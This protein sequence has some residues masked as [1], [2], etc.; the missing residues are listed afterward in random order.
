MQSHAILYAPLPV[1]YKNS[2]GAT[3]ME[4]RQVRYF[5]A[6]AEH[7]SY[8]KA[9]EELHI[10]VSPLSRQVRQL[11]DEFGVR[12]FAR[13]RRRVELTNAGRLFLEEARALVQ[14]TADVSDR[15]R[16]VKKGESGAVRV[17]VGL[18][19]GD[20]V[21]SVAAEHAKVHPDVDIQCQGIFSTLQ[22]EA[23]RENKIDVGFLRPPVD[24]GL[25]SELLYEERLVALVG[26]TNPLSKRKTIRAKDLADEILFLPDRSVG[27]GLREKI[28]QLFAKA[29]V[30]PR[31]SS[32]EA[33]PLGGSEVHKV[34]LAAN[35]G[36]FIVADELGTR[37]EN[38]N[39]AAAIPLDDPDAHIGLYMAWRK[40]EASS[41]ILAVLDTARRVLGSPAPSVAGRPAMRVP[42]LA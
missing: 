13:D 22:N 39:V 4:L 25:R 7:L 42:A 12:L 37:I 20:K 36:V 11:E 24:P 8:S 1:S 35:K 10:S 33:D 40:G 41:S 30:Q 16:M 18:H 15:L 38:S 14:H 34:L 21:G 2:L 5:I 19:L 31:V 6:V 26:K 29:G 9:A 27:G 3:S 32:L 17:G 28:L 23:L